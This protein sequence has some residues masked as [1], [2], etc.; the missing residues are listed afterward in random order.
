[1]SKTV[2]AINLLPT[3]HQKTHFKAAVEYQMNDQLT[4]R[5]LKENNRELERILQDVQHKFSPHQ[6]IQQTS[7]QFSVLHLNRL[8]DKFTPQ[9]SA[10]STW[11][12]EKTSLTN[13]RGP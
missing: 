7:R 6:S 1:M 9:G 13:K 11:L 4:N 12:N 2:R 3:L 10:L 5:S 8:H